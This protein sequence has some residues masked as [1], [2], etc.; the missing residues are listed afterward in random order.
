MAT[1]KKPPQVQQLEVPEVD[2]PTEDRSYDF[3]EPKPLAVAPPIN[4]SQGTSRDDIIQNLEAYEFPQLQKRSQLMDQYLAQNDTDWGNVIAEA[5]LTVGPII[6]GYA[7]DGNT[8]GVYGTQIGLNAGGNYR[9][10][11]Q[12]DRDLDRYRTGLQLQQLD[13]E[14][15]AAEAMRQ[16]Y[17][18]RGL[19]F[20]EQRQLKADDREYAQ[21]QY[22]IHRRDRLEDQRALMEMRSGFSSGAG[23]EKAAFAPSE[24]MIEMMAERSGK[25]PDEIRAML[26]KTNSDAYAQTQFA[27]LLGNRPKAVGQGAKDQIEAG[28]QSKYLLQ[29]M[30]KDAALMAQDSSILNAI[31]GGK[32][33]DAYRVPGSPAERFYRNGLQLQKQIVRQNDGGRPTDKDFELM[34]PV[35]MG[36]P[37]LDSP[38]SIMA[39][40]NDLDAYTNFKL[41][42]V[43]GIEGATGRK[44]DKLQDMINGV[45][46]APS[47]SSG[48]SWLDRAEAGQLPISS[49]VPMAQ[50]SPQ[51]MTIGGKSWAVGQK[52]PNGKTVTGFKQVNGKWYLQGN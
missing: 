14:M 43:V 48:N 28:M 36:S 21:Q 52:L 29:E 7:M 13:A 44:I 35:V 1:K 20:G 8:G 24:G 2:Y 10:Q 9:K 47:D 6:A 34:S 17:L 30:R 3:Y 49:N 51:Q 12:A 46:A 40:L 50:S 33:S 15:S 5:L 19:E 32:L 23:K 18:D 16:K 45:G 26:P 39:R 38:E 37:L 22:D 25:T 41:N 27:D 4:Y 31:K 42:N 11:V